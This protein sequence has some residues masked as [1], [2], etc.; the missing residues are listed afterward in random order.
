MDH[1]CVFMALRHCLDHAQLAGGYIALLG[2]THCATMMDNMV[3]VGQTMPQYS[4][5][6]VFLQ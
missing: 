6:H 4:I 3:R 2:P 5:S 1:I